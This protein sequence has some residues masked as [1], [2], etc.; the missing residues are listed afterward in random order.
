MQPLQV[1]PLARPAEQH[2]QP[3]IAEPRLLPRQLYQPRAQWLVRATRLIPTS[4]DGQQHQTTGPSLTE[5]VLL[6]HL[7][8]SC[9]HRYELQPFF[10]ITDCNASLSSDRS[11]TSLR[12]RAFSSRS[13]L[14]SCACVASI[15]PYFAFHAYSVCLLT[16]TS[17]ATSSTLRPAS[18]CFSAAIISDSVCLLRDILLTLFRPRRNAK[19][20][21]DVCGFRRAG[22]HTKVN[23]LYTLVEY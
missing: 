21:S 18:T 9:L 16:P 19:S 8:D 6:T 2:V 17:R 10:R 13:C 11:A 15:P 5:G 4:R 20:Y 7:L 14:A 12:S 1:H 22:Q 3:A 23:E